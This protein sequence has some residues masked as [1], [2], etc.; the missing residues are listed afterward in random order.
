MPLKVFIIRV[1]CSLGAHQFPCVHPSSNT[2]SYFGA[3]KVSIITCVYTVYS[4]ISFMLLN[5]WFF[6]VGVF[7][8]M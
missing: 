7:F 3:A 2:H 6:F 4:L 1:H 8:T 5:K